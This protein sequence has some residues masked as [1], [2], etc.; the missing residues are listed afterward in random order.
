M[1]AVSACGG[2]ASPSP[3]PTVAPTATAGTDATPAPTEAGPETMPLADLYELAKAEG[4]VTVYGGGGI[5][6]D[7]TPIFEAEFPGIKV[8]NVDSTADDLVTRAVAEARG[9]RVIGDVWQSPIDTVFQMK[10]QELLVDAAPA[11]AEA[12]PDTLKGSYWV[13]VELQFLVVAWNTNLVAAGDEPRGWED[14]ADPKWKDKLIA[15]P[16]DTQ[17][18]MSLAID[19]YGGDEQKAVDLFTAIAANNPEFQRGRRGIAEELL[20]AGQRA[21]CFTCN[22]HHFPPLIADGAPVGFELNEARSSARRSSTMHPIRWRRCSF[23][24]GSSRKPGRRPTPQR[25]APGTS[26]FPRSRQSTRL[27]TSGPRPSM[28]SGRR[29][30]PTTSTTT[31]RCGTGSSTSAERG[32]RSNGVVIHPPGG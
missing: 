17:L 29:T 31:R 25:P 21:V 20:P 15:D 4:A 19:K 27:P 28:P 16:R 11:E 6:P 24:A 22:S 3:A 18:L 9:G 13:A 23:I 14:L 7:I 5:I 26:G 12:Y 1:V 32:P 8:E 30:S 10:Q 2:G